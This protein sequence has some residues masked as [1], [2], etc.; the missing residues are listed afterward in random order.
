MSHFFTIEVRIKK[1][2]YKYNSACIRMN[3]ACMKLE[4]YTFTRMIF[5]IDGFFSI[6]EVKS[7]KKSTRFPSP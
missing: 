2:G 3:L 1:Q 5:S 6:D 7:N 4:M